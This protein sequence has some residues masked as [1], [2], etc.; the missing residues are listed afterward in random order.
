MRLRSLPSHRRARNRGRVRRSDARSRVL[1]TVAAS[2]VLVVGVNVGAGADDASTTPAAPVSSLGP[3][4]DPTGEPAEGPTEPAAPT[5]DAPVGEQTAE[6]GNGQTEPTDEP[7]EE[8]S[9]GGRPTAGRAPTA[10]AV[11][12]EE[13]VVAAR[14]A[15]T[16]WVCPP[17]ALLFQGAGGVS[18]YSLIELGDGSETEGESTDR[19]VNAVGYNA[20]QDF[21]YGSS[22]GGQN[23]IVRIDSQGGVDDLGLPLNP[24]GTPITNYQ[25]VI[26]DV[27][28]LGFYWT[29]DDGTDTVRRIRTDQSSATAVTQVVRPRP[30]G[31]QGG[32][33]W[34]FVASTGKFWSMT[35][36]AG[37]QALIGFDRAS[38]TWSDPVIMRVPP[39]NP[40]TPP[41]AGQVGAV[42]TDGR[43]LYASYNNNGMIYRVDVTVPDPGPTYSFFARG[44]SSSTND[45][46]RCAR[47][48]VPIDF[49]DAPA[50]Y[51][52]LLET[53]D[54]ARHSVVNYDIGTK[55]APLRLGATVDIEGNGVPG[56]ATGDDVVNPNAPNGQVDDE[57]GIVNVPVV[58]TPGQ[59]TTITV[60]ATNAETGPATLA[61]WLDTDASGYFDD[62]ERRDVAVP[63]GSDDA[64]FTLTFPAMT[65]PDITYLRLRLARGTSPV[66]PTGGA[67]AGEVEDYRVEPRLPN[68][69]DSK[70]VDPADG[71]SVT[72]GQLV[73][74]TLRFRNT[75]TG[76][77][78][79]ARDDV[80]SGVLDDAV[81]VTGPVV[82]DAAGS[83]LTATLV[84]APGAERIRVGGSLP[85]GMT[86]DATV[87][88]T[89]RVRPAAERNDGVL[90][91]ALVGVDA[92]P[93]SCDAGDCTSNPVV[94]IVDSKSVDPADGASV[95]TGQLVTYTLRFRNTGTGPGVV[96]RDDVLSGVLDD[97]VLVTGPVVTDA[98][99]S[100][101]TATL[102]GA[103]GA[104]RIRVGGSLPGGMTSDATVTYT[105]RVR[106]AAERNDGVLRNALVGV[107]APPGSCD[108]GDCTSNPVVEI[109]DS[110]SVDPADGA[111]VTTGQLVTY[112]LRFRNTGTGPGVVARDDVLSGVLDDAVLVTGPVVTDAAGSAL[113]ATLVGAPGAERIRVGGS[114]PGGMTSDATVTYTVRVR[115][116]AERNDGVLRNALVG[117]DA[118][119]GSCDAGD[120][121]SNPVAELVDSKSV[122]P[123]SGTPVETGDLVTY[124]LRFRNTGTG[125]GVVARDDVLSGV[126]DDATFVAGSLQA[127]APLAA[128]LVGA[129]GSQRIQVRGTLPAGMTT[130]ATVTYQ[131]RVNPPEDREDN[132]LSNVLVD[133]GEPGGPCSPANAGDCTS[134]PMPAVVDSKSVDPADGTVVAANQVVTYTLRFRNTGTAAGPVARDDVLSGVLD[135][136]TFVAGSLQA[137]APLAAE[138]VGAPGSQRIQVRGTLPAGM[139][140]DATVTYQVRVN[141]PEDREDNRLSNVLVDA[142]EP[143]G[144]CSPANAGDCTSNPMPAV[145]DSK[146]VDPADG[147]VVAANQVVTYTLRFRNTGTAA[148]PVAR[149]DVLSGVLDDATFVAGS[150]QASAPLAAELVGAPGSQRIQVRGTLPAGMTTDATVTYQVRVNPPEDR[151]DNRLSN[152]LVDAGEPGGPCSPANAGDCTSNPMPAVVDSKSVDPADGTTVRAGQVVTY[153]LTFTNEGPVAGPVLKDDDLSDVLDDAT[154]ISGPQVTNPP[155]SAVTAVLDDADDVLELRGPLDAGV[156][157]EVTY[158]VRVNP[159]GQRQNNRLGN[160]L[161]EPG[162]VVPECADGD[163]DCTVNEMPEVLQAK[164]V[165][166]A[167]GTTV[168]AG[169]ELTY[170]LQFT[171]NGTATGDVAY[172]DVLGGVLDDAE[173]VDGPESVGPDPLEVTAITDGR[174]SITG[175][176]P[177]G[178]RGEV[179]YTV[180]VL[181]DG[182][183]NDNLLANFLVTTGGDAPNQCT[184]DDCT[185]NYVPEIV[186]DKEASPDSR[187]TVLPGDE[188]TYRL[189]FR[190]IGTGPGPV[191]KE[192]VLSSV[193]DDAVMVTDPASPGLE[194]SEVVDERFRVTG[195]LA[196]GAEA[197]VTYVVRVKPD[198]QR[199]ADGGDHRLLNALVAPGEE[200]DDRCLPADTDCTVHGIPLITDAKSAVPADTSRVLP[201]DLVTYTLTFRNDGTGPGEVDKDDVVADVVD[202]AEVVQEP[203]SSDEDALRASA[204]AGGRFD[205][206]GELA[207]GEVVTVTYAVRVLSDE[208]RVARGGND[209]LRNFLVL[210]GGTPTPCTAADAD[211]TVHGIPRLVDRKSVVPADGSNVLA[212]QQLTYTL[213]FENLGTAPGD[214]A[215]EDVVSGVLDDATLVSGPTSSDEDALEAGDIVGDRFAITGS[216]EPGAPVTITYVVEVKPDDQRVAD[217][218]DDLLANF[219]VAPGATP[220]PCTAADPDCTV[221][222][223]PRLVDRKDT[224]VGD[225]TVVL[226]G[227]EVTYTLTFGNEGT[228]PGDVARDDDLSGVLDD[229]VLVG[230]VEVSDPDALEAVVVDDRMVVTGTL[231]ADQ[232]ETVTYTVRVKPDAQRVADGGDD[233][234]LNALVDAGEDAVPCVDGDPDCTNQPIPRLVDSKTNDVGDGT[235]VVAGDEVTYTLTFANEGKGAGDLAREDDLTGVLDDAELVGEIEVS[236]PAL[237]AV[238]T[239]TRLSVTGTLQPAQTVTVTYTVRV[240]PDAERFARGADDQLLNAIVDP[241]Q[242]AADCDPAT[243]DCVVNGIPRLRDNKD[244]DTGSGT[245]VLPGQVVTYQLTF[246][247]EGKGAGQVNREDDLSGVLDDATLVVVPF[248]SDETALQVSEV[249]DGR[250]SV[251]G[252]LQPGQLVTV[253]YQAEVLPDADRVANG[254]DDQLLNYLLDPGQ[255]PPAEPCDPAVPGGY[256]GKDCVWGPIPRIVEA[257]TVDP[258]SGSAAQPGDVLA[259]TLTFRNEGKGAGD[260]T[261]EDDLTHV[262]DDTRFV[263]RPASSDPALTVRRV[264]PARF[265]TTGTLQAAQEVT[266]GYTVEVR[267]NGRRGDDLISNFLLAPGETVPDD[268]TVCDPASTTCTITYAAEVV[269]RKVVRPDTGTT[270]R[271]GQE[272]TYQLRFANTGTGTGEVEWDDDLSGVL[273]DAEL[274]G[275]PGV[276]EVGGAP[277][278]AVT[279]EVRGTKLLVRGTMEPGDRVVVRYTVRVDSPTT[280]DN[281]LR[282]V[283]RPT[284]VIS[285][286]GCAPG[287]E[288]CT[289][290]PVEPP[291]RTS[292]GGG[293]L[294][295]TGGPPLGLLALG[296]GLL[297]AGTGVLVVGATRRR[298]VLHRAA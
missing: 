276:T 295:D 56:D 283:L 62:D 95:T 75:G 291:E 65:I 271:A 162:A 45:G 195:E 38:L 122:S 100:A 28:E 226:Q 91:N 277:T 161:I 12:A 175:T 67:T 19:V 16:P 120:C 150:L 248:S 60:R 70:S 21:V 63:A 51:G 97:A 247:N 54:G 119:P 208:E 104:E 164:I 229:A 29:Y 222:T 59:P 64:T 152:V 109:V 183:R 235:V 244:V 42:F 69:V 80:L 203:E 278:R 223:M 228:G 22:R 287:S 256:E 190:N 125:A 147:T 101:L 36:V 44:P 246:V 234:L 198:A 207:A 239:D 46:A 30:P 99:G 7:A 252:T 83:A 72:T 285:S 297:L 181:P 61:G 200:A 236:A 105:V 294:P 71:A 74:Y 78:V 37:Q 166:P 187:T 126:L 127:S 24:D 66:G 209:A 180:R 179:T 133:A 178:G 279:A 210:P 154:L 130:D 114:L 124:T 194:V 139:T 34:A 140:T 87:T 149:D 214:V 112:T 174:F 11:A 3:V 31:T 85:G 131:V 113:T 205:V 5:S 193:L 292:S 206:T 25:T 290:N 270:V 288:L 227:E 8:P 251:T 275:R 108:A 17:Q 143:G 145:V 138:L 146:S 39:A 20:L 47:A 92:P 84:G 176:L 262:L 231:Q 192:D 264:S 118:P 26:G 258:T 123:A 184:G 238:L 182:E 81:L 230:E 116:A 77:G 197:V 268:P 280:G 281:V 296:A 53:L 273:D 204:I 265:S 221:H 58:R 163:P 216:V 298:R 202:D 254:G 52:T 186:D 225:G 153:T 189:V 269:A 18:Q 96:A 43:Y 86:S 249:V 255:E 159:E 94:E 261:R 76:P 215:K 155:G 191:D 55:T 158:A 106:P 134:N 219:L 171:N 48:A 144:P 135:D 103:P 57:D 151:E 250:F 284:G 2:A 217:G 156:T 88:Y 93:G 142:G 169:D 177:P 160:V 23:H 33:D 117:V 121:T 40:N 50:S 107:D 41:G 260:M 32:A 1:A 253:S 282:N 243:D 266:V 245:V 257:K 233:Q 132:R 259:Y 115:P 27:D 263:E 220:G 6:P 293:G 102:V 68:I 98:A 267:P 241:G 89:V 173:I 10:D 199:V 79:V 286:G 128:E 15:V 167:S 213:T 232:E 212:G 242:P 211:C 165:T 237:A 137:S 4:G 13:S 82:T 90:R 272:V 110:K 274:V 136:A 111:S 240:L 224:D 73:T 289:R 201:G 141:P 35:T 14:D 168:L 170:T 49:G 157:A 218:G 148:G 172:D 196:A 129:P 9:E 188:V 185:V